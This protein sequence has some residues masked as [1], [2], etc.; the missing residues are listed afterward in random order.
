MNTFTDPLAR[1]LFEALDAQAEHSEDCFDAIVAHGY[2]AATV[3]GPCRPPSAELHDILFYGGPG[4]T[5]PD[6]QRVLE[7]DAALCAIEQAVND[8]PPAASVVPVT[9]DT[10][11]G[12]LLESDLALWCSGFMA[13]HIEQQEPA[14]KK[15]SDQQQAIMAELILPV[16][17]LSGL[18]EKEEVF[19][20]MS[21]NEG[22]LED[23][24]EQ[25]PDVLVEL[26]LLSHGE[27]KD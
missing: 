25:L 14:W 8:D 22:L 12:T 6:P 7:I 16:A 9:L 4:D 10:E 5:P 24:A 23:M 3:T 18:F 2:L 13:A 20:D 21:E 19:H 1:P 26:Y 15:F 27:I 17:T 11:G